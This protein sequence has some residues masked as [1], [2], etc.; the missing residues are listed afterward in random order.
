MCF[1]SSVR[2]FLLLDPENGAQMDLPSSMHWLISIV[3][4]AAEA[5]NPQIYTA[6]FPGGLYIVTGNDVINSFRSAATA[7]A[8]FTVTK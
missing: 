7:V 2:H 3:P 1:M 4:K 8:N 5:N 6:I